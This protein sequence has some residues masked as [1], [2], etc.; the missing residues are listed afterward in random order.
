MTSSKII[1]S[2]TLIQSITNNG[3]LYV[4]IRN[5]KTNMY[6]GFHRT[7]E[8]INSRTMSGFMQQFEVDTDKYGSMFIIRPSI[9]V[10][11]V[12]ILV[13][14]CADSYENN[15]SPYDIA[16]MRL[17][18]PSTCK[19]L[20]ITKNDDDCS[21]FMIN[22]CDNG[23][24]LFIDNDGANMFGGNERHVYMSDDGRLQ[25]DGDPSL[26]TSIW[27]IEAIND[28]HS[29]EPRADYVELNNELVCESKNCVNSLFPEF[30]KKFAFYNIGCKKYMNIHES[31]VG[32]ND[33]V[34]YGSD[35]KYAF[36]LRPNMDSGTIIISTNVGNLCASPKTK[37]L[38]VCNDVSELC[39]FRLLRRNGYFVV[40]PAG[41]IS[42][43]NG[44]YGSFV[45]MSPNGDNVHVVEDESNVYTK[46]NIYVQ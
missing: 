8:K 34:L 6:I 3:E 25:T 45:C 46:W 16:Y 4:R 20:C 23:I 32:I 17:S 10:T 43:D 39:K 5:A 42:T 12:N 15:G 29:F 30:N 35:C 13:P 19:I 28:N 21:R 38:Y 24:R 1:N 31:T 44:Q 26:D 40:C 18:S 14:K 27:V 33:D 11:K 41:K 22:K 36:T 7:T 37:Q 9:D 2:F